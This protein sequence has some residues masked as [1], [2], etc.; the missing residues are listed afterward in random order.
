MASPFEE[1]LVI[2][3]QAEDRLSRTAKEVDYLGG[4]DVTVG[5]GG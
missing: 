5:R 1:E 4:P 2:G 3:F